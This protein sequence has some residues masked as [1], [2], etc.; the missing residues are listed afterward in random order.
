[1]ASSPVFTLNNGLQIPAIGFGCCKHNLTADFKQVMRDALDSGFRYLDTASFYETE[2]DL[3]AVVRESGID[4]NE[5][6]IVSKVW[7]EEMG[8]KETKEAFARSL[9]RMGLDYIDL[10]LIH[11]PKRSNDDAEWKEN[12][13]ATW[14]A[15][16]EFYEQGLVKAI[17][18]CNFLPHHLKNIMDNCKVVPAVDQLELHLGYTQEYA[19]RFC[20]DNGIQPQA[21]SPLGR[22]GT[23]IKDNPAI[24]RMAEKYGVSIQTLALNFLYSKGIMSI[25]MSTNPAHMKENQNAVS[26][27]MDEED[28]SILTGMPQIGWLGEHPD[29]YVPV[30][31]HVNLNQ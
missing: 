11:W 29:F 10:Y 24:V 31:K 2:R 6:Q 9:D 14:T 1:M 22:F 28:V 21:W 7:Y 18:V 13:I 26:F 8:Y 15:L 17:G 19:L 20:K 16:E 5:I 3:G 23:D 4:R 25:P 27:T 12:D 30:T